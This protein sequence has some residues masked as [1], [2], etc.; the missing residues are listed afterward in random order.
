M[1]R[2]GEWFIDIDSTEF[3]QVVWTGGR[4]SPSLCP[5]PVTPDEPLT[6]RCPVQIRLTVPPPCVEDLDAIRPFQ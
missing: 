5:C 6:Y 3:C 4:E 2:I 1:A